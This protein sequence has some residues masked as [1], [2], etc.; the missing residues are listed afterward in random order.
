MTIEVGIFLLMLCSV[1]TGLVVEAVKK[2]V[3]VKKPN[4]TAAIVSV[5]VGAVI[6]IM[7]IVYNSLAFDTTA[8]LYII[9]L[10]VLSWLCSM[11][12]YEKVVQTLTQ[13]KRG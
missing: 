4:I 3:K 5:I 10:I 1:L 12:G 2:M 9:S 7:Y 11:L 6:P 8:I 13:T